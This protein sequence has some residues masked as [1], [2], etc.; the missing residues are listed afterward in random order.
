MPCHVLADP[1]IEA[2]LLWKLL[3]GRVLSDAVGEWTA[4][5]S[6]IVDCCRRGT[7][8]LARLGVVDQGAWFVRGNKS[9]DG[10]LEGR[11]VPVTYIR[12]NRW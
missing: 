5:S 8:R 6:R 4:T 10:C 12:C 1:Y 7:G 9:G 3:L 11:V 2:P